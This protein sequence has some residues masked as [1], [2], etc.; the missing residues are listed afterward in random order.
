MGRR[1]ERKR[2]SVVRKVYIV[3]NDVT[4][5]TINFEN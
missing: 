2:K 5:F 1:G 3:E 4:M